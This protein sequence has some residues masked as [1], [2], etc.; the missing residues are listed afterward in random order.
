MPLHG[1]APVSD[2]TELKLQHFAAIIDTE[3]FCL[4]RIVKKHDWADDLAWYVDLN[5]GPGYYAALDLCGS[6]VLAVRAAQRHSL[7]LAAY[8]CE[9]ERQT[10]DLLV[11]AL[12]RQGGMALRGSHPYGGHQLSSPDDLVMAHTF[13]MDHQDVTASLLYQHRAWWNAFP[14]GATR[15]RFGAVSWDGNG[16]MLPL[17]VLQGFAALMPFMD[18]I[19]YIAP[20]NVKRRLGSK[21]DPWPHTLEACVA[22]IGKK[23]WIVREP[24][25]AH[26][27]TFLIGTNWKDY[28][29]FERIGFHNI[30]SPRG[31]EIFQMLCRTKRANGHRA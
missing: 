6:P 10:H 15:Q 20:T 13:P 30:K 8:L 24:E 31:E 22:M 9:R 29:E 12:Q 3:M 5:G 19:S 25:G 1:S 23:E 14:K 26:Q 17:V 11:A 21:A 18:L 27:W 16:T 4:S 7:R 2:Y 28:P